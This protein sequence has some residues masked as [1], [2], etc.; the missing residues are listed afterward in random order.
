MNQRYRSDEQPGGHRRRAQGGPESRGDVYGDY[1]E[2]RYRAERSWREDEGDS[3]FP[4]DQR[5]RGGWRDEAGYRASGDDAPEPWRQRGWDSERL[6]GREGMRGLYDEPQRDTGGRGLYGQYR[7]DQIENP[8]Y[9]QEQYARGF[10]SG[11]GRFDRE[12][13]DVR[14]V[15]QYGA[16]TYTPEPYYGSVRPESRGRS[17]GGREQDYGMAGRYDRGSGYDTGWQERGWQERRESGL[18]SGEYAGGHSGFGDRGSQGDD[19]S[20]YGDRGSGYGGGYGRG[21]YGD[22]GGY[23]AYGP[24]YTGGAARFQRGPYYGRGP[25]NYSRS[26]ERIAEDLNERLTDDPYL[27]ASDIDVRIDDGV[28]TLDGTVSERWMKYRAE[29][30]ADGCGGVKEVSNNLRVQPSFERGTYAGSPGGNAERGERGSGSGQDESQWQSP[31]QSM[32][33]GDGNGSR[34]GRNQDEKSGNGKTSTAATGAGG[35]TSS[36]TKRA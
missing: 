26:D 25:R 5:G 32:A 23:E 29:D 34:T 2:Q 31:S 19:R 33:G 8:G 24:S 35:G 15:G 28:A 13:G 9:G 16:G 11:P 14:G 36:S 3:P 6:G 10:G 22:R 7:S 17:G 20:G 18:R 12:L 21:D 30:I 27:D 4:R 1:G